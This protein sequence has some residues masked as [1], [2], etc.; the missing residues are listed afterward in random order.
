MRK[1][2][3]QTARERKG[4]PFHPCKSVGV[5]EYAGF[6]RAID[7]RIQCQ[8][9]SCYPDVTDERCACKWAFWLEDGA[10]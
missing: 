8:C 5:V 2:R 4:L 7:A 3:V 1:C 10:Q 9:L 6:A